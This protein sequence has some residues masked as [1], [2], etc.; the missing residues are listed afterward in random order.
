MKEILTIP[1]DIF[2]DSK[3]VKV[4]DGIA[5]AAKSSAV[6]AFFKKKG[7]EYLRVTST[8]KLK[9]DALK[10]FGGNVG[11]IAG[12][13]FT[14][15]DGTFFKDFK[16]SDYK[17]VVID[18]ILQ[19]P[20]KIYEWIFQN[21]GKIN[22]IITTDSRQMLAV[23]SFRGLE[24]FN[25]L[26]TRKDCYFVELLYSHRPINEVTRKYF[27]Y[28]Y[29]MD[30]KNTLVFGYFRKHANCEELDYETLQSFDPDAVYIC[31]T[32]EIEEKLYSDFD[33]FKRYDLPCLKKGG[34]S[35]KSIKDYS[36]YPIIPQNRVTKKQGDYL[37]I[38]NV[39]TP[40]RFQGS[41]VMPGQTL[42]YLIEAFS[43]VEARELYTVVTRCKDISSLKIVT[44]VL[45]KVEPLETFRGKPIREETGLFINFNDF[46]EL[47]PDLQAWEQSP[48]KYMRCNPDYI[49]RLVDKYNNDAEYNDRF[50]NSHQVYFNAGKGRLVT[51]IPKNLELPDRKGQR[52]IQSLT[53]HDP[54]LKFSEQ[55]QNKI[56]HLLNEAMPDGI[57]CYYPVSYFNENKDRTKFKFAI[58]FIASYPCILNFAKLPTTNRVSLQRFDGSLNFHMVMTDGVLQKGTIITDELLIWL[59]QSYDD[60]DNDIKYLFSTSWTQGTYTGNYLYSQAF[61]SKEEKRDLKRMHYGIW[62][63][64]YIR[65]EQDFMVLNKWNM[66]EWL[67]VAIKNKQLELILRTAS[68]LEIDDFFVNADCIYFNYDEDLLLKKKLL[69]LE[70]E[71]KP[72]EFRIYEPRW[73]REGYR[74][75]EE[76][77]EIL[78]QTFDFD[79]GKKCKKV[80]KSEFMEL[81]SNREY[82]IITL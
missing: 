64:R 73:I 23:G 63:R 14:T 41:E 26:K 70:K 35:K 78:Y 2:E 65:P 32:N 46:Q 67:M 54:A 31:H 3:I 33:L 72:F 22:I 7:I 20:A 28:L 55:N 40:T 29:S 21:V 24:I 68:I 53:R 6:D 69:E 48:D 81:Q 25:A 71:L 1:I 15:E 16:E 9:D 44:V 75:K 74:V 37:Q 36:R 18:E 39:A 80:A 4:I 57:D 38:A 50:F 79:R 76:K 13:L 77:G 17:H 30:A 42:Y 62:E 58:D 82:D 52:T 61:H 59:L 45:E 27:N 34:I 56:Y 12:E 19:V 60:L 51:M 49:E 5:G 43:R 10:R 47:E 8:N 11:T 66:H